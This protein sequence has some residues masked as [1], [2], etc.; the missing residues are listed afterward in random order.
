MLFFADVGYLC[1]SMKDT[2]YLAV[3]PL[4]LLVRTTLAMRIDTKVIIMN[5]G[6]IKYAG[7]SGITV[8]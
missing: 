8:T 7:N 1:R 5:N 6:V 3:K 4:D 2:F